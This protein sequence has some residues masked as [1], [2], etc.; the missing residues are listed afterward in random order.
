MKRFYKTVTTAAQDHGHAILLDGKP[1]RTPGGETLLAPHGK[2]AAAIAAEW[3]AQDEAIIP[4][5]MP[6]TQIL[7]TAIDRVRPQRA[8]IA[9]GVKNYLDTDLLCYR[10]G[11]PRALAEAQAAQWDPVLH[12]FA[13]AC[14]EKLHCTTSLAALT[15]PDAAHDF[16]ARLIDDMDDYRFAVFQMNVGMTGSIVLSWALD[17]GVRDEEAVFK[18]LHVEEDY[19]AAI[20]NEAL[21]G[22][23]PN[24]EA[25]EAAIRRDLAA[26][27][28]FLRLLRD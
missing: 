2:L 8:L 5:D 9:E 4:D 1:V 13:G 25:R 27:V 3:E 14:G 26:A 19:K 28:T 16:V 23:A 18:A 11:E 12:D 24:Q 17:S 10:I 7:A 15:Q 20:Y 21:H 22:R 6:L